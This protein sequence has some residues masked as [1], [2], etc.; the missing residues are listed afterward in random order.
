MRYWVVGILSFLGW[1]LQA[2]DC[3]RITVKFSNYYKIKLDG[4]TIFD[5]ISYIK[6]FESKGNLYR[7]LTQKGTKYKAIMNCDGELLVPFE[8]RIDEIVVDEIPDGLFIFLHNEDEI[9]ILDE[10]IKPFENAIFSRNDCKLSNPFS[11]YQ[12]SKTLAL[13][14][15]CK[16]EKYFVDRHFKRVP[17]HTFKVLRNHTENGSFG[18][19]LYVEVKDQSNEISYGIYSSNQEAYLVPLQKEK[20]DIFFEGLGCVIKNKNGKYAYLNCTNGAISL[21]VF[22]YIY[23]NAESTQLHYNYIPYFKVAQVKWNGKIILMDVENASPIYLPEYDMIHYTNSVVLV[24]NKKNQW[25]L[26]STSGESLITYEEGFEEI[27]WPTDNE[28]LIAVKKNGKWGCYDAKLKKM[29]LDTIYD[30]IGIFI[31]REIKVVLNGQ[32]QEIRL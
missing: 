19:V 2:Q 30:S 5:D 8:D 27:R 23:P 16:G 3:P 6:T 12:R 29:A 15:N 25:A 18:E 28:G 1:G 10:N 24:L 4:K 11:Y 13:E 21:P 9:R 14:V 22:D 26:Y 32:K 17:F 31:N 7:I 20:I